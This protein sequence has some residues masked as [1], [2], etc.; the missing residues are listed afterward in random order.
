MAGMVRGCEV[1]ETLAVTGRDLSLMPRRT[2]GRSRGRRSHQIRREREHEIVIAEPRRHAGDAPSVIPK[3][4]SMWL[5]DG[6]G[7]DG[8][9]R[10]TPRRAVIE[11]F[12][13]V[14]GEH[15]LEVEQIL[16]PEKAGRGGTSARIFAAAAR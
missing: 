13:E 9:M 3:M 4:D 1:D 8:G 10:H 7:H 5:Y 2:V 14:K 12:A 6:E 16:H 11:G 15:A